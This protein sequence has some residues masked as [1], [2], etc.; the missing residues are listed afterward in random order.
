MYENIDHFFKFKWLSSK[1][2]L[3]NY[4]L[5]NSFHV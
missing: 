2:G 3:H 4:K 1:N 5:G